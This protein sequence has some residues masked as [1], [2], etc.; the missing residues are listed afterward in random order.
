MT[1]EALHKI[2]VAEKKSAK[3]A[4]YSYGLATGST[5]V[6]H[7]EMFS[8][9][10]FFLVQDDG[11][12]D[13][14]KRCDF[15]IAAE[16]DKTSNHVWNFL[17]DL[18]FAPYDYGFSAAMVSDNLYISCWDETVL[19]RGRRGQEDCGQEDRGCIPDHGACDPDSSTT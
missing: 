7:C 3:I 8:E 12:N 14:Y 9:G 16:S 15:S 17:G 6:I 13:S 11:G 4:D 19:F 10:S 2:N 1:S 5:G 18:P